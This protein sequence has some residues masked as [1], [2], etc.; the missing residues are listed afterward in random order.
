MISGNIE[1]FSVPVRNIIGKVELSIDGSTPITYTHNGALKS[2]TVERTGESKFF[3]F[4][5]GQK[6]NIKIIDRERTCAPTTEHY[7]HIYF[8]DVRPLSRLYVSEVHRDENNNEVS[9][10]LYDRLYDTTNHTVSELGLGSYTIGEFAGA[11]ATF[12]GLGISLPAIPE[13][14]V[15]YEEGANF[16]GTETLREALNDVAEATQTVYYI[17]SNDELTFK[18]LDRDGAAVYTIDKS[19]YFTLDTKTNRRLTAIVS[20]TELG[21]NIEASTGLSGTSCIIH[22]NAFW[23]LRE[24]RDELVENALAATANLTINQFD[25]SWRGNYLLEPG[26][27]LA[28]IAKDNSEVHSYL[29]SDTITYDGAFSQ[30][31]EWEYAEEDVEHTNPVS[32]GETLKQT[33]AKVDKVN[34]EITLMVSSTSETLDTIN[35][36]LE[37]ISKKV[38][39]TVSK[40]EVEILFEEKISNGVGS[41]ETST[42]FT[43]NDEGLTVSK[44]DS[45]IST[46]I[47]EDGM[48]VQKG[49]DDVL[50]AN[51]EGV[52]AIDLHAT[53][54]LIVGNNSRFEDY[55]G[56]RTAC[57]WIGG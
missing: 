13:F 35:G 10:T 30:K 34:Q 3:G 8:D 55:N 46:T 27:K 47:T 21:D 1:K 40:D 41:V 7:A 45:D 25:C 37:E 2:I 43:F 28:L 49:S 48:K 36:E 11:I 16:N 44:S 33:I 20:A 9:I 56:S 18:R 22:D 19:K 17:N 12:L 4:G 32:L 39:T 51:N 42:G 15:L 6:A 57:F 50:T 23:D 54:F 5:I 53:T 14:E 38:S 31:T 24:D 52:K 29:L 26:D